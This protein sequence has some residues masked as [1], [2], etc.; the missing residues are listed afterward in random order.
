MSKRPSAQRQ[1]WAQV[2]RDI[3]DLSGKKVIKHL[4]KTK[5]EHLEHIEKLTAKRVEKRVALEILKAESLNI[6]SGS[7]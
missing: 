4:A 1:K 3:T 5:D 7:E 2:I 6:D